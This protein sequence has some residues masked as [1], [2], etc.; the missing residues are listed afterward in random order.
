MLKNKPYKY[1]AGITSQIGFCA[2]PLR[3]DSYNKCQFGCGYCFAAT[4]Q[5]YGRKS[6]L[7]V[8][9]PETLKKRLE[10][11]KNGEVKSA[12]DEFVQRRIPF[13]LGGMS[14]PFTAVERKHEVTLEFLKI[15]Q[16][17][18]YPVIIST[19]SDL[20]SKDCYVDIL[21]D[22]NCYIRFSTTVIDNKNRHK[23]DHNCPPIE[24]I[25]KSAE[26][27]SRKIIPISFR[28]QPIIPGYESNSTEIINNAISSGVSH[29]SAEYLKVPI[30]AN[31]KFSKELKKLLNENPIALYRSLGASRMGREYQLP[32][33]YRKEHLIEMYKKS[34]SNGLTFGFADNDLLLHS[35]GS[36]CCNASDLYLK[37]AS[38]FNG[39]ISSLAKEKLDGE[40]IIFSDYL[41][42]WIPENKISTYL[43]SKA[44][45]IVPVSEPDWLIYLKAM[46]D[47]KLGIY[48]PDYFDGIEMTNKLDFDG[49]YIYKRVTSA[50][51]KQISSYNL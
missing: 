28:L 6:T 23:I 34:K 29:I 31:V 4:R 41:R 17:Y 44:R 35:D 50:F 1:Y 10:R 51:E 15:L 9:N 32:I 13:Q 19:K 36:A 21:Q 20:I 26:L 39:N 47:G 16:E 8:S 2:T 27:L 14:D 7:Q 48:R 25:Y 11:V 3:L 33:S 42:R 12:L 30:D 24:N 5:G 46:W 37:S 49:Q 45:V 22:S 40:D 43:N 18:D 38:F